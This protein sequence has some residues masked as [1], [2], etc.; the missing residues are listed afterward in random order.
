MGLRV[1]RNDRDYKLYYVCV[2]CRRSTKRPWRGEAITKCPECAEPMAAM[3]RDFKP[4][5]RTDIAG[6]REVEGWVQVGTQFWG[7][8]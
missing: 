5:R 2:S 7:P 8:G 1:N 3:G 4:P 6:W